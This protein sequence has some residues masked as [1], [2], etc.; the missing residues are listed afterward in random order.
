MVKSNKPGWIDWRTSAARKVILED[1]QPGGF[2]HGKDAMATK[3]VWDIYRTKPAFAG[4]AYGQFR[5]RLAGHRKQQAAMSTVGQKKKTVSWVSSAAREILL[6]DLLPPHGILFGKNHLSA[7]EVWP[8]YENQEGFEHVEFNYFS[9]R[10]KAHREQVNDNYLKSV[11]EEKFLAADRLK[12]PKQS[13]NN[14]GELVFDLHPARDLLRDDVKHNR[15]V[16]KTPSEIQATR[17]NEY[18]VFKP[19]IFSRKVYQTVRLQK[20]FN[21]LAMKQIE[22]RKGVPDHPKDMENP[23]P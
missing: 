11:E 7:A 12:Y 23:F 16:G 8:F 15:H 5:D 19:H 22:K 4:V 14:R 1:L 20:F 18:G 21:Y 6:T 2:L 3:D 13:V 10:L 9:A 17:P